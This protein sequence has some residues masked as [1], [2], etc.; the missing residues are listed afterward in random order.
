MKDLLV[1]PE[2]EF[3]SHNYPFFVFGETNEIFVLS[4]LKS[5]LFLVNLGREQE[6]NKRNAA[7][8]FAELTGVSRGFSLTTMWSNKT[9]I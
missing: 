9:L 4:S 6:Q 8:L 5:H 7:D 1:F 2:G 3:V